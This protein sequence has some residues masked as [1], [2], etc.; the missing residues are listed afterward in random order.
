WHSTAELSALGIEQNCPYISI[1]YRKLRQTWARNSAR[2]KYPTQFCCYSPVIFTLS[3]GI[4]ERRFRVSVTEPVLSD[5][6]RS[7]HAIKL[8]CV[9]VTERMKSH[10]P[11][12][13][14]AETC[15]QGLQLPRHEVV[16]VEWLPSPCAKQQAIRVRLPFSFEILPD[17]IGKIRADG[18]MTNRCT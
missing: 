4:S 8:C 13:G 18:K 10:P 7:A 2:I 17:V 14:D 12:V 11:R 1:R 6:D 15:E 5:F 3:V 16:V 9:A